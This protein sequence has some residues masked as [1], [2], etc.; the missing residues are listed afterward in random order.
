MK[1]LLLF[2][3]VSL[4]PCFASAQDSAYIQ[5]TYAGILYTGSYN[6]EGSIFH[7]MSARVGAQGEVI[8]QDLSIDFRAGYDFSPEGNLILGNFF[9]KNVQSFGTFQLG[10]MPKPIAY[11]MRPSPIS[12]GGHF[13]PPSLTVMPG[14]GSGLMFSSDIPD[15]C[16]MAGTYYLDASQ[17][18]EYNFAVSKRLSPSAEVKLAGIWSRINKGAALSMSLDKTSFTCFAST[19]S[20]VSAF[21]SVAG[22]VVDPYISVVYS[23]QN[24]RNDFNNFEFGW[25]KTCNMMKV[26]A[27]IGL[28]YEWKPIA[29]INCYVQ[30]YL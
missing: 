22:P 7:N 17:S 21:L 26:N 3:I 9:F 1:S 27:L 24:G 2:V 15:G 13:E 29:R 12:P 25:T 16:I 5:K 30:V 19:D 8:L 4:M 6:S 23:Y 28:A 18:I 10:F 11:E 14:S 20:I